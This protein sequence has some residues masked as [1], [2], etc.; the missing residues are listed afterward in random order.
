LS[1]SGLGYPLG[2]GL[3]SMAIVLLIHTAG[4][5]LS[6]GILGGVIALLLLPAM[7][8]LLRDIPS[9]GAEEE[10]ILSLHGLFR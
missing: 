6:W 7:S 9:E 10:T 1:L 8:S 3:L 2:E 4:W 5:R